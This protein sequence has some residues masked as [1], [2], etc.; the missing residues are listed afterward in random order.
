MAELV[1]IL[2]YISLG[3]GIVGIFIVL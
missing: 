1:E 2:E 3:I